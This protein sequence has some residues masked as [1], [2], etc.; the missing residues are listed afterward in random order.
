MRIGMISDQVTGIAPRADQSPP[1]LIIHR[2]SADK[3]RRLQI[4]V[5]GQRVEQPAVGLLRAVMWNLLP[6]KIVDCDG[7]LRLGHF[8]SRHGG[9]SHPQTK[10]AAGDSVHQALDFSMKPSNHFPVQ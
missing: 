2:L 8:R 4:G 10:L 1:G 3:N 5:P 9:R 7:K 6:L